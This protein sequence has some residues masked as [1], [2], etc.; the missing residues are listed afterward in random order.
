MAN[1]RKLKKTFFWYTCGHCCVVS[2]N[3]DCVCCKEVSRIIVKIK[4][5]ESSSVTCFTDHPGFSPVCLGVLASVLCTLMWGLQ[6]CVLQC[7][8][9]SS[10]YLDVGASVLCA[11]MWGLQF[12]VP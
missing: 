6:V 11:L 10:V 5:L 3:R 9:F 4:E 1:L 12:C 8:G 7:V 2:P